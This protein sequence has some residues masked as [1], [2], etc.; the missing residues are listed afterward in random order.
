MGEAGRRHPPAELLASGSVEGNARLRSI[1]TANLG[2]TAQTYAVSL[3]VVQSIA[4]AYGPGTNPA[5]EDDALDL[6]ATAPRSVTVGG[7]RSLESSAA[8]LTEHVVLRPRRP[9]RTRDLARARPCASPQASWPPRQRSPRSCTSTT[10]L[11]PLC[12]PSAGRAAS[13]TSSTTTQRQAQRGCRRSRVLG[14]LRQPS[15]LCRHRGNEGQASAAPARRW[16]GNYG[17][18]LDPRLHP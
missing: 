2:A 8:K 6:G 14:P 12:S 13:R 1:G 17:F 10:T 5:T 11:P 15:S 7:I 3:I 18:L 9:V 16:S 4:W